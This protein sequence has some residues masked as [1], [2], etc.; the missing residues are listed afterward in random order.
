M[1]I[2]VTTLSP[3]VIFLSLASW[4]LCYLYLLLTKENPFVFVVTQYQQI[5]TLLKLGS[6]MK[7]EEEVRVAL[8][9]RGTAKELTFLC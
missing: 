8:K 2:N 3:T 5:I 7:E 9:S 4:Q 1:V 6:K